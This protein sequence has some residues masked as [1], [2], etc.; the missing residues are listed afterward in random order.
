MEMVENDG[1]VSLVRLTMQPVT[2][3]L[4]FLLD[5]ACIPGA[6]R[7]YRLAYGLQLHD[8]HKNPRH[9]TS[10]PAPTHLQ[11]ARPIDADYDPTVEQLFA[12]VPR[13]PVTDLLHG[14]TRTPEFYV[15]LSR[16]DA[17]HRLSYNLATRSMINNQI[18]RLQPLYMHMPPPAS[19]FAPLAPHVP[20]APAHDTATPVAGKRDS[21]G[22]RKRAQMLASLA[23]LRLRC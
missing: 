6:W 23:A 12:R 16:L 18:Y 15:L 21:G 17:Q 4:S 11:W 8:A 5:Q 13:T 9:D 2:D 10:K 22:V 3:R 7:T 19:G 20:H 14:R 1:A